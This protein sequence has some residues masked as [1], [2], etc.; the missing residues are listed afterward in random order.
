MAGEVSRL[1][2]E[3]RRAGAHIERTPGGH[4]RVSHPQANRLVFLAS[5]P[6]GSRWKAN[7]MTE[8]RH[9]GIPVNES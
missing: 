2:R 6:S 1:L 4:W 8:L 5:T 7:R 9:A 3:L